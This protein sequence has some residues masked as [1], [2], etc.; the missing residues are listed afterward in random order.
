MVVVK[1]LVTA[2]GTFFNQQAGC[3]YHFEPAG[4]QKLFFVFERPDMPKAKQNLASRFDK[5]VEFGPGG[6]PEETGAP[7]VF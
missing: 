2:A 7:G 6:H 5:Q 1:A 4:K 3:L